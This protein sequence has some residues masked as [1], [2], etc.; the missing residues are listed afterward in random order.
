MSTRTAE[1]STTTEKGVNQ[2]SLQSIAFNDISQPGTYYNHETGWLY[3][4]P[5]EM[6][7]EGHSPFL[8]VVSRESNYMT[9]ISDDPWIPVGKA[10]QLCANLDFYVNF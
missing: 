5:Q 9:K 4:V 1:F 8:N 7:A 2:H 3:R 6:L 10:R